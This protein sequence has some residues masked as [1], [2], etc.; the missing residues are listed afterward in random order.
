MQAKSSCPCQI[1]SKKRYICLCVVLMETMTV[2]MK[3]EHATSI[4][5]HILI[6]EENNIDVITERNSTETSR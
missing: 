6:E 5:N 4:N 1:L 3:R 2:F